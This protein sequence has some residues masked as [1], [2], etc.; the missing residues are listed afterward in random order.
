MHDLPGQKNQIQCKH[1]I[2]ALNGK[3]TVLFY[4]IT[5]KK[6]NAL[7]RGEHTELGKHM[8]NVI[9]ISQIYLFLS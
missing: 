6:V 1:Y 4:I 9:V 5:L 8:P 7:Q 2:S 3:V